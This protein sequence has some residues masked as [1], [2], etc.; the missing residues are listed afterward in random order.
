MRDTVTYNRRSGTDIQREEAIM[1]RPATAFWAQGA[2]TSAIGSSPADERPRLTP[3][4]PAASEPTAAIIV[5]PGGGYRWLAPHDDPGNPR[6]DDPTDR[7]S[8]RPDLMVLCY[9]VITFI[10]EHH[11]VSMANLPGDDPSDDLRRS[12]SAEL[13]VT[14]GTPPTF[15]WHTAEDASVP[16]EDSLRFA[17]ALY[18]S[19]VSFALHIFAYGRH[20]PGLATDDPVVGQWPALCAQWLAQQ[21]FGAV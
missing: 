19:G 4:L 3:Y 2:S 18:R 15:I 14:S 17:S 16:V 9:P 12:L 5:C 20:G 10:G 8:C 13:H 1:Q 7:V 21:G 6:A 11:S